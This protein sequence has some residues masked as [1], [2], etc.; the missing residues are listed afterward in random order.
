MPSLAA[1]NIEI[2]IARTPLLLNGKDELISYPDI[3]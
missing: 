2:V 3:L 1:L